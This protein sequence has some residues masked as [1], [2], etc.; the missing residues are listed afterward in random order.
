[1]S[2]N[3]FASFKKF[4][5]FPTKSVSHPKTIATPTVLS[6]L[7]FTTAA[8]SLESLS[9]LLAATFCPFL[10]RTSIALSFLIYLHL[11]LLL[12]P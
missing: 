3:S 11:R 7:I 5:F 12:L 4:S 2:A 1:M 6:S 9:A 10:R 8:P